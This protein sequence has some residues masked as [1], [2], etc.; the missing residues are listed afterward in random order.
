MFPETLMQKLQLSLLI[1]S[2]V[3]IGK[4]VLQRYCVWLELTSLAS[5]I[6]F[7]LA[8]KPVSILVPPLVQFAP[9][10]SVVVLISAFKP[11]APLIPAIP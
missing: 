6:L 10:G 9:A 1:E 8:S 5:N 2:V 4:P 7:A 11:F 3:T